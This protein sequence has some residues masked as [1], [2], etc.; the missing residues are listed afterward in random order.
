MKER[1]L[2]LNSH[3]GTLEN[4][5]F[6][7]NSDILTIILP[8]IGYINESPLMYY[9][10]KIALELGLDVLCVNYGFQLSHADFNIDSELNIVIQES[11]KVIAKCLS[12]TYRMIIFIG[13]SMGTIIQ[14]HLSNQLLDYKQVHIYL[15]PVNKTLENIINYPCLTITGT[16]DAMIN[17]FSR[18][19]LE[20]NSNIELIQIDGANHSLE[21]LDVLKSIEILSSAMKTLRKFIIK[22]IDEEKGRMG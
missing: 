13:K 20:N 19:A 22:Q 2:F 1:K 3:W 21:C 15:T 18:S 14:N 17:N 16:D 4:L 8:G 5:F 6:D 9:S 11:E 10:R 7:Q 12:K